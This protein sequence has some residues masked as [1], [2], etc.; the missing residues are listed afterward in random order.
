MDH[1]LTALL[2]LIIFCAALSA[3]EINIKKEQKNLRNK[4][5]ETRAQAVNALM[6][7]VRDQ[8][9]E[10][11]F[12]ESLK[13]EGDPV[14]K[15]RLAEGL[16]VSRSTAALAALLPLLD[17]PNEEVRKRAV[18]AVNRF[19]LTQEVLGR[20]KSRL[21]APEEK[22][23]VKMLILDSLGR[24]D[25]ERAVEILEENLLKQDEKIRQGAEKSL[26]RLSLRGNAR[27]EK[28][29]NEIKSERQKAKAQEEKTKSKN[30][31]KKG[32]K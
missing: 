13:T 22:E 23:E 17:D 32:K 27:A 31:G 8:E 1:K 18:L 7:R 9:V 3:A 15:I 28:K 25:D 6:P 4:K 24:K 30:S 19:S 10:K 20:V 11:S 29:I 2:S 21:D 26:E 12:I 14:I 16:S 5:F